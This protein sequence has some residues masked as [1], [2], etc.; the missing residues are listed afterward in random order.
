MVNG[1]SVLDSD[2]RIPKH[3]S[4]GKSAAKTR[5]R[6]KELQHKE[7]IPHKSYD[8]DG[9]GIVGNRDLVLSK[10]F[11]RGKKGYLDKDDKKRAYKALKDG[12]ELKYIWNVEQ[13][14]K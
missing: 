10:L 5:T 13:A 7:F 2:I 12:I 9:D 1:H 14:G 6:L 4:N 11:D 8:L 3:W